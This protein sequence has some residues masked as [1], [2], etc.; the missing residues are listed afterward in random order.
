VTTAGGQIALMNPGGIR[1]NFDAGAITH[2][3]AFSVQPFSN[4]VTTKTYTGAQIE[5]ILEQQFVTSAGGTRTLIL[6]VSNGFTYT[7]NAAGPAGNKIDPSTIKLN[8]V[9][10]D[11]NATYRVTANNFLASGGDDFPAFTVGTNETTGLDDLV[12]LE[13]YL[14]ANNP[15]TPVT[16]A[17]ITR[18][19]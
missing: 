12:A 2:G 11:P 18:V 17:R 10:L 16:T 9:T 15:Y 3:E 5:A 4:I 8:G 6:A 1:S 14:G 7:W 13:Q 19:P